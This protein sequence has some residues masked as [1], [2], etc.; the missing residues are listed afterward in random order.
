MSWGTLTISESGKAPSGP[1][2]VD[3]ITLVGDATYVTGGT[4]GL[5]AALRTAK[6]MPNLDILS[7]RGEGDNGDL[8]PEYVHATDSLLIRDISTGAD[9]GN[10]N[11]SGTTFGLVVISK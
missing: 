8:Q 7:V 3:R 10:A 4:T 1:L 2:F 9:H 6:G 5:L 11:L